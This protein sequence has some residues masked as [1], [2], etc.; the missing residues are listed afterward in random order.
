M[1]RRLI[2]KKPQQPHT[3]VQRLIEAQRKTLKTITEQTDNTNNQEQ[4]STND[5]SNPTSNGSNPSKENL[6]EGDIH[7]SE[8]SSGS[9]NAKRRK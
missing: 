6:D 5:G 9:P 1:V 3:L 8:T 7:A 4:D 2:E